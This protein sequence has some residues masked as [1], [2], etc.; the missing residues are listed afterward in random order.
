VG[1]GEVDSAWSPIADMARV[2]TGVG[3]AGAMV[4][5]GTIRPG[6]RPQASIG[7]ANREIINRGCLFRNIILQGSQ[8]N[9]WRNIIL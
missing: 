5:P 7:K 6:S 8:D 3:E 4:G 2:E 9:R 1:F